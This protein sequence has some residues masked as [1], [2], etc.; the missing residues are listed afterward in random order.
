MRKLE[1]MEIGKERAALAKEREGLAQAGREPGAAADAAEEGPRRAEGAR[2]AT[3]GG[4]WSRSGAGARDR[5]DG[6]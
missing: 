3:S 5:L 2:S 1:E 4:R 6:R